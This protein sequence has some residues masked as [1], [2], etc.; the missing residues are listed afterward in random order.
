MLEEAGYRKNARHIKKTSYERGIIFPGVFRD[1][2]KKHP[3]RILDGNTLWFYRTALYLPATPY[4]LQMPHP[5][6]SAKAWLAV[7][8]KMKSP[9]GRHSLI[10][11]LSWLSAKVP[12]VVT[13]PE[14]TSARFHKL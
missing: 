12:R 4:S 14:P 13:D 8:L 2:H 5:M 7:V 11:A 10:V 3:R 1:E 9:S 6:S